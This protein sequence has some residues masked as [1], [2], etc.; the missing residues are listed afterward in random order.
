MLITYERVK[1]L[2]TIDSWK[3]VRGCSK[4]DTIRSKFILICGKNYISLEY[5]FMITKEKY[6]QDIRS[7]F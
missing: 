3:L 2:Q 5:L 6:S 1:F 7:S 4:I